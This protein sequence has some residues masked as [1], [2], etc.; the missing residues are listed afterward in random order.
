M[1]TYRQSVSRVSGEDENL[2]ERRQVTVDRM[3]HLV[4]DQ[5]SV[6]CDSHQLSE[7]DTLT[8]CPAN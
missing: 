6:V 5:E 3:W 4:A 7:S 8:H 1:S 2:S